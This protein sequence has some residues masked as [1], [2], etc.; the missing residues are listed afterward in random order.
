MKLLKRYP[1]AI[2]AFVL[3]GLLVGMIYGV[4][5]VSTDGEAV[6]GGFPSSSLIGPARCW[7]SVF[8]QAPTIQSSPPI[9]FLWV[10][11]NGYS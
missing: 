1:L 9:S 5:A 11:P 4:V 10:G 3:R 7:P 8:S 2:A 6:M